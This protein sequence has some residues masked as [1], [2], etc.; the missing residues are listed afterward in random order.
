MKK[1]YY[2]FFLFLFFPFTNFA[3]NWQKTKINAW[4]FEILLPENSQKVIDNDACVLIGK[5][6]NTKYQ[7]IVKKN[8]VSDAN[9]LLK[10]GI[11]GFIEEGKDEIISNEKIKV[12]NYPAR[13]ARLNTFKGKKVIIRVIV[14][15][16]KTFMLVVYASQI[17]EDNANKFFNSFSI[18]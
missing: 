5:V 1:N 16:N 8:Q 18:K 6:D 3:Q 13:E 2:F 7:V 17:D 11:D 9:V 14:A 12:D 10:E 15:K 4:D